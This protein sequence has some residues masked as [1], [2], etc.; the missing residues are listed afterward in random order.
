MKPQ[1]TLRTERLTLRPMTLAD[2]PRL[3]E[4]VD[5]YDIAL[6]TLVIPH[7]YPAGM[8]EEWIAGHAQQ[9]EEDRT[10]HFAIDDG[11]FAGVMSLMMKGDAI[12]ELGYW[13]GKPYWGRGYAS[14]AAGALIRY[15]F[16]ECNLHR[17]FACHYTRNPASGRV[18][19]KNGMT[20]EGTL[21]HHVKK[22]DEYLDMA[23]YGIL[24]DEWVG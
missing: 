8:A 23:F 12:G 17:I 9:Y 5:D 4:L 1:P 3:H 18:M 20:Y 11:Q 13:V 10:H 24:R 2:A 6:N 21:R 19:Q 7:P 15:G 14:E 22:W 16:E